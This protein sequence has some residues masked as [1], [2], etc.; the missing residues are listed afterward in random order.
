[1][2]INSIRRHARSIIAATGLL[3]ATFAAA[4]SAGTIKKFACDGKERWEVKTLQDEEADRVD[5]TKS[6]TISIGDLI[7]KNRGDEW[8]TA[9]DNPRLS[10]E[11]DVYKITGKITFVKPQSDGDIHIVVADI[12]TADEVIIEIVNPSCANVKKSSFIKTFRKVWKDW[13]NKFQ[14]K[15]VHMNKVFE[16]KGVLF[17][18]KRNHGHG[19][20]PEGVELHPVISIKKIG[21]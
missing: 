16:V 7:V 13:L 20:G 12:N 9:E 4:P 10:D 19:G 21:S 17:H 15:S 8:A 5:I 3:T 14:Q 6:K 1:M 18:D 2:R 11:F